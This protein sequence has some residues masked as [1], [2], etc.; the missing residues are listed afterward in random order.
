MKFIKHVSESG[1]VHYVNF[2]YVNQIII[3]PDGK[4]FVYL[5]NEQGSMGFDMTPSEI[6]ELLE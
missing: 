5:H 2:E 6:K 4:T 1:V 3:Y